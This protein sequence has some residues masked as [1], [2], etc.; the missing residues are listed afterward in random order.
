MEITYTIILSAFWLCGNVFRIWRTSGSK[1]HDA[2]MFANFI[3]TPNLFTTKILYHLLRDYNLLIS[4][5][6]VS[7]V[8]AP[9][10]PCFSEIILCDRLFACRRGLAGFRV[11]SEAVRAI[12][13]IHQR[14]FLFNSCSINR[15]Q[16]WSDIGAQWH[17]SPCF[18]LH[19]I[20]HEISKVSDS[21]NLEKSAPKSPPKMHYSLAQTRLVRLI[22]QRTYPNPY[23]GNKTV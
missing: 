14:R 13:E 6:C 19:F 17:V 12:V 5:L 8:L 11:R 3:P 21:R 4:Q 2:I 22:R 7:T 16:E 1:I 18:F 23:S 15:S 20:C 9:F 10:D